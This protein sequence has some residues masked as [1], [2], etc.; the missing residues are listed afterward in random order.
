MGSGNLYLQ[1]KARSTNA[2]VL[3]VGE[4]LWD[5]FPD[6][7]RLGGA[8]LNFAAH[9][10]R[11]GHESLL[12]SAVGT[13]ELGREARRRIE[14]LGVDT[15]LL[16]TASR[17]G[18]GTANVQIGPEGRTAF[19]IRRP[20]AYDQVDLS[21]EH[22]RR[23]RDWNPRWLYYGTLFAALGQGKA[24]LLRLFDAFPETLRFYDVNLRP[25][26]DSPSLVKEL[27]AQASVVKLNDEELRAVQKFTGL[28]SGLREFCVAGTERYGWSAV[29]VTLGCRG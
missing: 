9:A 22:V 18:T 7:T 2:R 28:P 27:L 26:F 12:I 6:S 17:F 10:A 8:P 25:G 21:E 5:I 3:V 14:A 4:V 15:R 13:D 19:L 11:L 20:A 24:V 23:L 29:S 1:D 16:Q